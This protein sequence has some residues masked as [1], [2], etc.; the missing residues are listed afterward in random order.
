MSYLQTLFDRKQPSHVYHSG[1]WVLIFL[2]AWGVQFHRT[3]YQYDYVTQSLHVSTTDTQKHSYWALDTLT[4]AQVAPTGGNNKADGAAALVSHINEHICLL[5][6]ECFEPAGTSMS[7]IPVTCTENG[8]ATGATDRARFSCAIP[9]KLRKDNTYCQ[10]EKMDGYPLMEELCQLQ[11]A[12]PPLV[13][14]PNEYTT[15]SISAAHSPRVLMFV[16]LTI[17]TISNLYIFLT[18]LF[19]RNV[20]WFRNAVETVSSFVA[21]K[22]EKITASAQLCMF[23]RYLIAPLFLVLMLVWW[24]VFYNTT[25]HEVFWPKPFGTIF[26]SIIALVLVLYLGAGVDNESENNAPTSATETQDTAASF[27]ANPTVENIVNEKKDFDVSG[28]THSGKIT[29]SAFLQPGKGDNSNYKDSVKQVWSESMTLTASSYSKT[30]PGYS[31]FTLMQ[32]WV[33]PFLFLSVYLVKHNFMLD[34]NITAIFV[35]MLLF[36]LLEIASK[37]MYES[38]RIFA[39][40]SK[41]NLGPDQRGVKEAEEMVAPITVIRLL[42]LAFQVVVVWYVYSVAMW[43]LDAKS[44]GYWHVGHS[45]PDNKSKLDDV[46]FTFSIAFIVY[47]S[48]VSLGK[49]YT[50]LPMYM[51]SSSAYQSAKQTFTDNYDGYAVFVLNCFVAF[52]FVYEIAMVG[53]IL[54]E[55]KN[56]AFDNPAFLSVLATKV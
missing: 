17:M 30:T 14:Q 15:Y 3:N 41:T 39:E 48:L 54:F 53:G 9:G 33:L 56:L 40:V 29:V 8:L 44:D 34:S 37:R 32:T 43:D 4:H 10:S 27:T 52:V 49:L 20:Q 25:Q 12:N 55:N 51:F 2:A 22:D 31:Y 16:A 47:F 38:A 1:I 21:G 28:F 24:F 26:Y 36:G 5:A 35:G 23:K 6:H 50:L 46:Q 42:L 45:G 11:F 19:R 18:D 13:L 7:D